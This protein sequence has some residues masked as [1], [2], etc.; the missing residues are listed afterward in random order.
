[1]A[2]ATPLTL[3]EELM[4]LALKD[5]KGTVA[6]GTMYPFAI[7]GAVISELLL[8]DR[9]VVDDSK[10]RGLVDVVSDAPLGD[11]FLDEC[12]ARIRQAKRRGSLSTWVSRLANLKQLKHRVARSLCRKGILR[13]DEDK[14]LLIFR[15]R[16]YPEV[17][18]E[19]ERELIGRL[20]Q[21]IFTETAD[22]DARTAV[23]VALADKAGM[24]KVV[25]DRK[26]LKQR[27][28][29]LASI[30]S[31]DLTVAATAEAI[32]AL[33]AAI[34]VACIIPTIVVTTTSH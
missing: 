31:G 15:R 7:G 9:I 27:K 34:V 4:L 1:M 24:L 10:K 30:A 21:A 6:P 14:V 26:E 19:P 16:I 33:Q 28:E 17:A 12:L 20:R 18:P 11:E 29:R 23:L 5:D 25:F 22:V 3:A 32:Q 8:A 2:E 13:E